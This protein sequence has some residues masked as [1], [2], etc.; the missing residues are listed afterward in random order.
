MADQWV[1]NHRAVEPE[2]LS[3]N[4]CNPSLD[5]DTPLLLAVML[6]MF[7]NLREPRAGR[8]PLSQSGEDVIRVHFG[9]GQSSDNRQ[10]NTFECS[11][12]ENVAR[13]VCFAQERD[14]LPD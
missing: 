8:Q 5:T 7:G 14:T 6:G 9:L 10:E 1:V 11:V 2:S 13:I 3:S 4:A 12:R